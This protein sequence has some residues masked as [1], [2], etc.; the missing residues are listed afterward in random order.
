MLEKM[1][2]SQNLNRAST[3]DD[4]LSA[5]LDALLNRSFVRRKY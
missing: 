2:D 1:S 4:S 3:A 5:P